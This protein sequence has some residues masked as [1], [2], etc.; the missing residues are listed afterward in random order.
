MVN[1]IVVAISPA[2]GTESGGVLEAQREGRERTWGLDGGDGRRKSVP[3]TVTVRWW[4]G[5]MSRRRADSPRATGNV[6]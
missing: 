4:G 6:T 1:D 3:R 5:C 2:L